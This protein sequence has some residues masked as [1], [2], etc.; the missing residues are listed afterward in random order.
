MIRVKVVCRK[1]GGL[2]QIIEAT[3]HKSGTVEALCTRCW[4]EER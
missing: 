4:E 2:I 3:K 1:C